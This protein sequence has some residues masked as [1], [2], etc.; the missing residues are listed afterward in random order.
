MISI[1]YVEQCR[2]IERNLAN[3]DKYISAISVLLC[4]GIVLVERH[5]NTDCVMNTLLLWAVNDICLG[6][7]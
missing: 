1:F 7:F 3:I 5:V 4:I 2:P 6:T